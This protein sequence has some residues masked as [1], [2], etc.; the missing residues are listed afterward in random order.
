MK[1]PSLKISLPFIFLCWCLAGVQS[2]GVVILAYPAMW[3]V[4]GLFFLGLHLLTRGPASTPLIAGETAG[5]T[6]YSG[7]IA[8]GTAAAGTTGSE[9]PEH[10]KFA[11]ASDDS[12]T[13]HKIS[14]PV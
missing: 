9:S 11:S 7:N 6:A 8:S 1:M 13:D 5:S 12:P 3:A 4:V 14:N 10:A 2:H